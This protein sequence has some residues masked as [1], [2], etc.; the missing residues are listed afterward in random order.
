MERKYWKPIKRIKKRK[1]RIKKR[2]RR[3]KAMEKKYRKWIKTIWAKNWNR[4]K[5]R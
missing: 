5:N 3:T 2:N 1:P 4:T